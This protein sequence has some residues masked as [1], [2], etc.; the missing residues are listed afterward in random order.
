MG[1]NCSDCDLQRL[2]E[3][4]DV[5]D[6]DKVGN[7]GGNYENSPI[8]EKDYIPR[9]KTRENFQKT[10]DNPVVLNN[11]FTHFYFLGKS[12]SATGL[13]PNIDRIFS[14][15]SGKKGLRL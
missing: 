9:D 7:R 3:P 8:R 2:I 15:V 4:I 14:D 6:K 12:I 10:V 5:K 11:K 1:N 13:F